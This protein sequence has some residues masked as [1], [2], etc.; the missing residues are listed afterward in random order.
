[1]FSSP[2]D[3]EGRAVMAAHVSR[4]GWLRNHK[5]KKSKTGHFVILRLLATDLIGF[6]RYDD[7]KLSVQ[8]RQN[9][10]GIGDV[11]KSSSAVS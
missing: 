2:I 10:P 8:V 7:G 3:A 6:F 11:R 5:G 9:R 4:S 1:M